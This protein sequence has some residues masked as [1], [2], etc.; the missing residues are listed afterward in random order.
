M[1][2]TQNPDVSTGVALDVGVGV[3]C[4][5]ERSQVGV[6]EGRQCPH[7]NVKPIG[8]LM[9]YGKTDSVSNLGSRFPPQTLS[10]TR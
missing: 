3:G 9:L 1:A 6:G 2:C 5:W 8:G 7:G 4:G 10:S